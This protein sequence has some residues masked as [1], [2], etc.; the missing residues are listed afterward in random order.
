MSL[1]FLRLDNARVWLKPLL[2]RLD[3]DSRKKMRDFI[4]ED[5]AHKGIAGA[6]ACGDTPTLAGGRVVK[7]RV[8]IIHG[9]PDEQ[10]TKPG[11]TGLYPQNFSLY[12]QSANTSIHNSIENR[13][14]WVLKI[15]VVPAR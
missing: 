6:R 12:G 5:R 3:G 10:I 14:R 8:D 15:P 7:P 13:Q 1:H 4:R 2:E 9:D 11:L